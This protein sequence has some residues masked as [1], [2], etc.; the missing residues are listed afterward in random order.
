M[1]WLQY[2]QFTEATQKQHSLGVSGI[3]QSTVLVLSTYE[4]NAWGAP[5]QQ[6]QVKDGRRQGRLERGYVIKL[7]RCYSNCSESDAPI[8][9]AQPVSPSQTGACESGKRWI[10][11]YSLIHVEVVYICNRCRCDVSQTVSMPPRDAPP[12]MDPR[13]GDNYPMN[14]PEN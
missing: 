1:T 13:T 12:T 11:S 2:D 4:C 7:I 10:Y 14:H 9:R 6:D 8:V 5:P 3:N